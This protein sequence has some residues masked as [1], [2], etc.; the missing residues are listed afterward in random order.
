M[1]SRKISL[2]FFCVI[3]ISRRMKY[4]TWRHMGLRE[5]LEGCLNRWWFSDGFIIFIRDSP[6]GEPQIIVEAVYNYAT[7]LY[8]N[9]D[10]ITD[11][12]QGLPDGCRGLPDGSSVGWDRLYLVSETHERY[13]YNGS[14]HAEKKG[15]LEPYYI[16]HIDFPDAIMVFPEHNGPPETVEEA[17]PTVSRILQD[18][19]GIPEKKRFRAFNTLGDCQFYYHIDIS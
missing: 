13:Y 19:L 15:D 1:G 5:L 16:Q 14:F 4:A 9:P 6:G 3:R 2:V 18:V 8:R 10:K 7:Y 11:G 12:R 17:L